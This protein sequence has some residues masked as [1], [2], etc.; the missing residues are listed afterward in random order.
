MADK[1]DE[2]EILRHFQD[3]IRRSGY[4]LQT[5]IQRKLMLDGFGVVREWPYLDKDMLKGRSIDLFGHAFIPDLNRFE[6]PRPIVAQ[7]QLCIECKS[8]P[9][10]GWIFFEDRDQGFLLHD[11]VSASSLDRIKVMQN[12]VP[13]GPFPFLYYAASYDEKIIGN[14]YKKSNTDKSRSNQRRDNL[15]GAIHAVTKANRYAMDRFEKSMQYMILHKAKLPRI[16]A[17]AIFQTVIVFEGNMYAAKLLDQ[18][19]VLEPIKYA[20][21]PKNYVSDKYNEGEG[22]IHIVSYNAFDEYIKLLRGYY[23]SNQDNIIAKQEE[24][25]RIINT[26]RWSDFDPFEH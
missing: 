10:H 6:T 7:L 1:P 4:G 26:V 8:L 9:D 18:E 16:V 2:H 3:Q 24:L 11:L 21:L 12:F 17:F 14:E 13:L 5:K 22:Y 20:R 23:W 19:T 15:F 25:Q